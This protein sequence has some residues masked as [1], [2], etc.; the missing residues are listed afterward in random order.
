MSTGASGSATIKTAAHNI[1]KISTMGAGVGTGG[2]DFFQNSTG[3]DLLVGTIASAGDVK[4]NDGAISA[5]ITVQGAITVNNANVVI[6]AG[7]GSGQVCVQN[8]IKV[9]GSGRTGRVTLT[10]K[11]GVSQN[12]TG[13][14]ITADGLR[15]QSST[16][17]SLAPTGTGADDL[18]TVNTFSGLANTTLSFEFDRLQRRHGRQQNGISAATVTLGPQRRDPQTAAGVINGTLN[19][20]TSNASATLNTTTN[21]VAATDDQRGQQRLRA[22]PAVAGGLTVGGRR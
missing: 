13:A 15:A 7:P 20:T 22:E 11:G 8:T 6:S 1:A 17:L 14:G 18:N 3:T 5:D 9:T 21:T 4:L 10:G 2:L 16:G 19:V 12:A